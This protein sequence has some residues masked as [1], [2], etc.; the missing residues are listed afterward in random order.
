MSISNTLLGEW[1]RCG[2]EAPGP[3]IK[4]C[5]WV[6]SFEAGLFERE[7]KGRPELPEHHK[8]PRAELCWEGTTPHSA[9]TCAGRL[10]VKAKAAESK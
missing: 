2:R 1:R 5:R 6:S 3:G 9:R 4:S 8:K 7:K 10:R